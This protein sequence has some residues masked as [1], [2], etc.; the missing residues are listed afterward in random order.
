MNLTCEG[1]PFAF[2]IRSTIFYDPW[3]CT[4]SSSAK[5]RGNNTPTPSDEKTAKTRV[6]S[7]DIACYD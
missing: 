6:I 2:A 1:N 3:H 4:A 5:R 7:G